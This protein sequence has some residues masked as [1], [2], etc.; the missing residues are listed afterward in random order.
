MAALYV[1]SDSIYKLLPGVD[2]WDAA[3]DARGYLGSYPVVA[4]PPCAQWARLAAFARQDADQKALGPLAID[5]VR[6]F[7]GVL[8]HPVGSELF[9]FCG[10]PKSGQGVDKYG[11]WTVTVDQ[12]FWGHPAAKKTRLY[13]VGCTWDQLPVIPHRW[14]Y[15]THTVGGLHW[16]RRTSR[17][18]MPKLLECSKKWREATPPAFATWLVDVA[19]RCRAPRCD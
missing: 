14:G 5:Q 9:D 11:G 16:K 13:I 18:D 7:G 8:E 19:R 17:R 2:A 6:A 4:H 10:I 12:W 3:R 15:P 1:R